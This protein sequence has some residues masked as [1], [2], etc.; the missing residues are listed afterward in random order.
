M[1]SFNDF[2][3]IN[4][5]LKLVKKVNSEPLEAGITFE[6]SGYTVIPTKHIKDER[7]G[8]LRDTGLQKRSII[9]VINKAIDKGL[10]AIDKQY[11]HL[12]VK[13]AEGKYDDLILYK[14]GKKLTITTIIL[15]NRTQPNYFTKPDDAKL[16]IEKY[17][18]S[19]VVAIVIE[20]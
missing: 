20:I 12:I 4:E 7:K 14:D 2:N 10:S 6:V 13:N 11:I 8:E 19:D 18:L 5:A 9:K 16:I 15:Q 1:I 17:T 3:T